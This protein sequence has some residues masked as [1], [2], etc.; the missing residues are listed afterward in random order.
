MLLK[1]TGI[2]FPDV[3]LE[4]HVSHYGSHL[5][6]DPQDVHLQVAAR[7]PVHRFRGTVLATTPTH[8]HILK[9]SCEG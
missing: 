5:G 7:E 6:L 3:K 1:D 9:D 8:H 2:V 4:E